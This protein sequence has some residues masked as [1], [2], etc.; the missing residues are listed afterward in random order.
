M[1]MTQTPMHAFGPPP[2][3][4]EVES[5]ISAPPTFKICKTV[6]KF[7]KPRQILLHLRKELSLH[8]L[9]ISKKVVS[10]HLEIKKKN[11]TIINW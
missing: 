5:Y 3:F 4:S 2:H 7:A 1:K 6:S 10:L 8:Y 11:R 9:F